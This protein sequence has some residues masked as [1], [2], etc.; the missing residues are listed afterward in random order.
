MRLLS[1]SNNIGPETLVDDHYGDRALGWGRICG[2]L[3]GVSHAV[4]PRV[5]Q[6]EIYH[7]DVG[8]SIRCSAI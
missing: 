5:D 4:K 1:G 3:S 8:I 7:M 2:I 6:I